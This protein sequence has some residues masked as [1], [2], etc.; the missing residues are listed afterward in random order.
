MDIALEILSW[1][2]LFVGS[3]F[4][5]IGGIGVVRLPDV[6]TR[7]H[8]AGIIDTMGVGGVMSGLMIQ[9]GFTIVT[10]K[11]ALIIGFILYTSPTAT[12][13]LARAALHGGV[14]PRGDE[15]PEDESGK[16]N[17]SSKT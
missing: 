3:A 17:S 10:I 7:M 8:G 5:V 15:T 4:L 12:H 2:L 11:L 13:A 16:G 14:R 9:T 6:F 1:G